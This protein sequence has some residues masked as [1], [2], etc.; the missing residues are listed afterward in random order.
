MNRIAAA[1]HQRED[2]V[3]RGDVR[4]YS[5]AVITEKATLLNELNQIVFRVSMDATKPAIRRRS[6]ACS[7]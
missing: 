7:V 4:D 5:Q 3:S 2:A 6:R 1:Q